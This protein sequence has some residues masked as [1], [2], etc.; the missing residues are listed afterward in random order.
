MKHK[1]ITDLFLFAAPLNRCNKLMREKILVSL[2]LN[3]HRLSGAAKKKQTP[4]Y[5]SK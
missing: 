3:A 5:K 4:N 2:Q 1:M